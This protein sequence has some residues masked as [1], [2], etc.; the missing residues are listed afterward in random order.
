MPFIRCATPADAAAAWQRVHD[1]A[2]EAA[3]LVFGAEQPDTG[4]SWCPDCVV[5]DPVLRAAIARHAPGLT[6]Y[7]CPVASRGEWKGNAA[8][9]YRTHPGLRIERIPTLVLMGG[10]RERGRLVE[11]DCRDPARVAAFLGA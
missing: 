8:H 2:G 7:E 6:V 1:A 3:F 10:G 9:P 4:A 5:A 11:A